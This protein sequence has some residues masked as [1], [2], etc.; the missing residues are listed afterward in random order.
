MRMAQLIIFRNVELVG[1]PDPRAR[2]LEVHLHDDQPRRV[3]RRVVQG[4]ALKEIEVVVVKGVP[5]QVCQVHVAREIDAEI[6]ACRDSPAGVLEFHFVHVDG[7]IGA[8]KVLKPAR[9]V[10]VQMPDDDRLDVFD[11]V[12]RGLDGVGQLLA[13]TVLRSREDVR[14]WRPPCL[15]VLVMIP[16]SG[17]ERGG[18]GNS[19]GDT[20]DFQVFCT[21]RLEENASEA[22]VFDQ[23]SQHDQVSSLVLG[24]LVAQGTTVLTSEKPMPPVSTCLL[25]DLGQERARQEGKRPGYHPSSACRVPRSKKCIFVPGG[26]LNAGTPACASSCAVLDDAMTAVSFVYL[27]VDDGYLFCAESRKFRCQP[28]PLAV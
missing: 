14:Q 4:D 18:W 16:E 22:R 23:G 10:E 26:H 19:S 11:V 20:Y 2:L 12:A 9:M 21:A 5:L 25:W 3:S 6:R 15:A 27:S 17:F 28:A 13:L 1:R 8:G 7:D 24:V